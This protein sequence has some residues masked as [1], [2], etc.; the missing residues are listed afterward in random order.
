MGA[1]WG[2]WINHL[3]DTEDDVEVT[4]DHVGVVAH[5]KAPKTLSVEE[6]RVIEASERDRRESSE[7]DDE[8]DVPASLYSGF[9]NK[10]AQHIP[11]LAMYDEYARRLTAREFGNIR[12]EGAL[13]IPK[14]T[15][16]KWM[17]NTN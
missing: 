16:S 9:R 11:Y 17:T 13:F 7:D 12:A 8:V 5:P 3:D 2:H 10:Y 6:C 15:E 4:H 14:R 1:G